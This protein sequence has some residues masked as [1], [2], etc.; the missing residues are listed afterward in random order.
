[1]RAKQGLPRSFSPP[2]PPPTTKKK[3]KQRRFCATMKKRNIAVSGCAKNDNSPKMAASG[4]KDILAASPPTI[5]RDNIL[6]EYPLHWHVWHKDS[7]SLEEE[8]ALNKHD[9]ELLDPRGRTP[10][11]LAVSLGY[12]NCVKCL[13]RGGC[14]ANAINRDG[15]NEILSLVLQHR[16]FQRG[17]QRLAGIPE[18]LD[19]LSAT[20]DSYVEMK[21]E[22]TSW[23]PFMS[24]MCPSDTYK[25]YKCGA[26]VRADTTL[27]GFDQ[28]DWQ[29][30]NRS[31][32]FK[33]GADGGEFLEIDHDKKRHFR[34]TLQIRH[35]KMQMMKMIL[36]IS[37]KKN[38]MLPQALS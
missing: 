6:S 33:G 37:E 9:K 24:R 28:N 16:D 22:F 1:M 31:Y 32:V 35:S 12:L 7:S 36:W 4:G 17:S 8:L 27:I 15:W 23:V 30:G 26:N 20:A 11:Q 2:P 10:L 18:L 25:I 3:R 13:L 5:S 38:H 19:E 21:W 29:R 14:D 34:E